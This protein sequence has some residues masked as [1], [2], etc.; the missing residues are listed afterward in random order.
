MAVERTFC[1]ALHCL[2]AHHC[3]TSILIWTDFPIQK[4]SQNCAELNRFAV[5]KAIHLAVTGIV[6]TWA[7][8][9]RV[10]AIP[11]HFS[12]FRAIQFKKTISRQLWNLT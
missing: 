11:T 2:S 4:E 5:D 10:Y 9:C 1:A 3:A 8:L 12:P 7:H 6:P